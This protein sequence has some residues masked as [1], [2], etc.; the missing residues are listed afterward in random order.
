MEYF[1]DKKNLLG[2]FA[3]IFDLDRNPSEL[4]EQYNS[5]EEVEQVFDK[6]KG[7]LESDKTH[8]REN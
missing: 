6:V 3:I 7:D 1:H 5:R 4:Y 8:L 2:G